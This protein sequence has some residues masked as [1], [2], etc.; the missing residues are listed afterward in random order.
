MSIK[1]LRKRIALVAVSALGA[2]LM[3]VVAVP[4]ANA[5]TTGLTI[6]AV[7]TNGTTGYC[8]AGTPTASTTPRYSVVG[9][10]QSFTVAGTPTAAATV[11]ISGNAVFS[12]VDSTGTHYISS[13]DRKTVTLAADADH[14]LTMQFTGV[15][16]V[17]VTVDDTTDYSLYFIVAAS[18]SDS[19][20]AAASYAQLRNDTSAADSNI[21]EDAGRTVGYSTTGL[22]KSYLAIDLNTAYTT[23][24]DTTLL[25]L[26]ATVTGGC[27]ASF[28]DSA[29]S[30]TATIVA[31]GASNDTNNVVILNDNTPRSCSITM[32]LGG[33]QVAAKTVDFYGDAASIVV[34]AADSSSYFAYGEA[35]SASA[36]AK[37]ANSIVY[38]VKD[39]AGNVINHSAA[40][41]LTSTTAGF[42]QATVADGTYGYASAVDN[43]FATLDFN[44]SNVTIAGAGA[45]ALKVVRQSD[46]QSVTSNVV[47]ANITKTV[48]TFEVAWD[49]ASYQIGDIMTLTITGKDSGGR[50][51]HDGEDL[52]DI[53]VAVSGATALTTVT[54]ADT[55]LNGVKKYKFAAGTTAA[56]YGWSVSMTSGSGMGAVVGNYT[57]TNPSTGVSNAEVLAAIVK[58]IASINKQI[59]A[60]QKSLKR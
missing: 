9:G 38:M 40:P 19:Y 47:N 24:V 57:I 56:T 4:T 44:A 48:Y 59:K 49:K 25:P 13:A 18:C 51:T 52:A 28:T 15:G 46:G 26:I 3:S 58:L 22:Q 53:E 8:L 2:G 36:T 37:N 55:F 5:A 6:A 20:S 16:Q 50:M 12:G 7:G 42:V 60:L 45:Y 27:T 43:G 29:T 41:T 34:S 32:T 11:S 54:E 23:A 1:T 35:G 21:D 10:I 14:F 31:T 17:V 33:T 30:G 39:S